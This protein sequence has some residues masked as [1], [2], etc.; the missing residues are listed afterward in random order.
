M[1]GHF[2]EWWLAGVFFVVV[3]ALQLGWGALVYRRPDRLV[4]A[5][6]AVGNVLVAA[7]WAVSRTVGI[8]L[9]QE[10]WHPEPVGAIDALA[11][12]DELVIA[13][14]VVAL[15]SRRRPAAGPTWIVGYVL[16]IA[17][18]LAALLGGHHH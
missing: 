11:T 7:V 10:A 4:L 2:E 9:G 17:S 3:T 12:L 15:L 8:P 16:L 6:G 14:L 5:A 1:P 18:L 13:G